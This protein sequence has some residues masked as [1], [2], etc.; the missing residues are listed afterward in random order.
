MS[1]STRSK[2]T[3]PDG[4]C[5]RVR[6]AMLGVISLAQYAMAATRSWAV[7]SPIARVRL[8]AENDRLRQHVTLLT[9]ELRIKDARMGQIAP[10][11]RPQYAPTERM[12][13]LELR[14]ARA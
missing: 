4:W 13:I 7:N 8:K 2:V 6:S 10:H 11:K 14:A 3:L 5:E 12:A 1:E 9:E